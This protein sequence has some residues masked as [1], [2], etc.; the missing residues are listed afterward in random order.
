MFSTTINFITKNLNVLGN[1]ITL[2]YPNLSPML[3]FSKLT[4]NTLTIKDK[5]GNI[6]NTQGYKF[7]SYGNKL[8]YMKE[9]VI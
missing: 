8:V 5:D 3:I 7:K 6:T 2:D 9:V 4:S 1:D